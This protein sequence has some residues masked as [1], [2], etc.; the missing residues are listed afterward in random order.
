MMEKRLLVALGG[1][2]AALAACGSDVGGTA[3]NNPAAG[4]GGST[5]A[6]GNVGAGGG[7]GGVSGD[8]VVGGDTSV[9]VPGIPVTS[10]IPRLLNRQYDAV[11]RDLLGVTTLSAAGDQPPSS[12]LFPD[13]DGP[14]NADA[15]SFYQD[16][17][18]MI[19]AEV[20]SGPNRS[21]FIS[22]DPAAAGC[23]T[24]T[25][26]TFGRRA[27]RRPL[28][29]A[30]AARFEA[31]SQTTPPGTPEEVAE[32][33]L[34]AFLVSPSFI[35]LTELAAQPEGTAIKLSSYEVAARLSFMLWGSVPDDAL[36]AAA[37]ADQLTTKEQILAQAQ[38][39]IADRER[40]GPLV[41][42]F[43]RHYADMDNAN[44]HWWKVQH[45]TAKYPL[46]SENALPVFQEELDAFFEDVA[47]GG[48]SFEDLFLSNVGF[49]NQDTA[50]LYGLD[51]V[52]YG[53]ELTRVELDPV[54]RPGFLTRL[55]FLSS[56]S[57]F[58]STSPIL[59]GAFVTVKLIGVDPGPPVP[60][61]LQ[62]AAP[63]G[64]YKTEREYIEALTGQDGCNGCHV[65]YVNPPG[66]VLETFDAIGSWQTVDPRGGAIDTTA[67][68]TFSE[69]N[70]KTIGSPLELMEEIGRGPLARHIYAQKW[71]SFA[72]GRQAN[73]ND[74]CVVDEL[75]TKLSQDGYTILNL[76]A[77]LTQADS[78]RLRVRGN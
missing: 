29:D 65:P 22:C 68:V 40:T 43:H 35:Q 20:M 58:D 74:A 45:D 61:A 9:C 63:P 57:R 64:D 1:L 76:L 38:R 5:A 25:I 15:W 50:A 46:Y 24:E 52:S 70:V 4:T 28:T 44:S 8:G 37:D 73:S 36:N 13:F 55:G 48:G 2:S 19:A 56:F 16:V 71:V 39:M 10:Q 27:F 32:T 18:A 30:E 21:N 49:V 7:S 72:T 78:F 12:L 62:V 26:R 59:R 17:G 75:D 31:L 3:S 69:D 34:Y 77:D 23:L 33:T 60:N 51:P 6:G 41:A 47:F 42:Q 11:V 53:P 14:M 66:F 54:Q 67:T